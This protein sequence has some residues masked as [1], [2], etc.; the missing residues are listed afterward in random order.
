MATQDVDKYIWM[1]GNVGGNSYDSYQKSRSEFHRFQTPGKWP[2]NAYSDR[3]KEASPQ[4]K[5]C[6]LALN[7]RDSPVGQGAPAAAAE[8]ISTFL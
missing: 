7:P 4:L 8:G 3:K 6:I 1:I 5:I 2:L